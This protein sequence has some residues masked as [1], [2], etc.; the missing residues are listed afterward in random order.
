M[1]II[2]SFTWQGTPEGLEEYISAFKKAIADTP[3]TKYIGKYSPVNRWY[4]FSIFAEFK[5]YQVLEKLRGNFHYKRDR[6]TMPFMEE[7]FFV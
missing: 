4:N 5:D 6:K 3:D 2:Q 1:I 7:E